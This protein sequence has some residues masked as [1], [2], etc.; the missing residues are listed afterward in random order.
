MSVPWSG[1]GLP[2]AAAER[3]AEI[4]GSGTWTSALSTNEFA[5]IRSVG[6][7]PVGQVMGSAVYHVGRSGAYWGY[8]DCLFQG[9]GYGFSFGNV[10]KS[11][12]ALSGQG[13]PSAG[14]VAVFE[15]ARSTALDRMTAE[16]RALGG[17]GVVSAQLTMAPFVAQPNC[18][19]F[20]V[21]GTAVRAQGPNRPKHPFT[22]H[23]DGQGFAKLLA[24]GWVPVELLVGMS[25]GVRHDDY[26]TQ[27]QTYS[28]QNVEVSGWSELVHKV[29]ADARRQLQLQGA[30]HGGDGIILAS[31][32]LRVWREGCIR[33]RNRSNSEQEDHVAESTMV[34]TTIARFTTREAAPRTLSVMP[35]GNRGDRLRQR[36]AAVA[37]SPYGDAAE[38]RRLARELNELGGQV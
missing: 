14:L 32:D 3:M 28:W 38:Y 24:S 13:A 8:H 26:R 5:A 19:E 21:I 20:K 9:A 22:S 7:E 29:R 31:S 2:P 37:S 4:K 30:R 15:K 6:F 35:L 34:A 23:L 25:I 18:L 36:L 16:C 11:P 1:T 33:A 17:D 10:G 27:S 12:V